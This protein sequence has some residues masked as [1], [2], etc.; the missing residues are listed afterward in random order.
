MQLQKQQQ[1]RPRTKPRK[2]TGVVLRTEND[3]RGIAEPL[4]RYGELLACQIVGLY[5]AI[6]GLPARSEHTRARLGR[7]FHESEGQP[8]TSKIIARPS[9]QWRYTTTR[10]FIGA[11]LAQVAS[12]AAQDC[13]MLVWPD[14]P[15]GPAS[16]RLAIRRHRCCGSD[17]RSS[18]VRRWHG[19]LGCMP[20][21]QFGCIG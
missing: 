8:A 7:L 9:Y 19:L 12:Y 6:H 15:A 5:N 17:F 20:V 4:E 16:F 14:G 10:R 13:T 1:R 3:V 18:R 2:T 21:G 11:R